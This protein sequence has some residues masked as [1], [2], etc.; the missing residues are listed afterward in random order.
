MRAMPR[1][2]ACGQEVPAADWNRPEARPCGACQAPLQ[3]W[4][5]PAGW[6]DGR[7]QPPA[8]AGEGSAACF[9]HPANVAEAVCGWCGRYLCSLCVDGEGAHAVCN[10]CFE[11]G[12]AAPQTFLVRWASPL[13]LA[14]VGLL[15]IVAVGVVVVPT[16][17]VIFKTLEQP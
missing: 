11:R 12:P 3:V 6:T 13:R 5:F 15:A 2:N 9:H 1:C 4:V 7:G 17:F 16:L 14:A 8:T 10:V